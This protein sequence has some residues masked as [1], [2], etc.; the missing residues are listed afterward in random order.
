MEREKIEQVVG[1]TTDGE[2]Y[3]L[4]YVFDETT[5]NKPFRGAVGSVMRPISIREADEAMEVENA[6]DR[7]EDV[8]REC[9]ANGDETRSLDDFVESILMSEGIE[10]MF[11]LSYYSIGE[12]VAKLYNEELPEDHDEKDEAE[13]SE[14]VGGGR[15]FSHSLEFDKVH[16]QDLLDLALS[17]ESAKTLKGLDKQ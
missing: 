1:R 7:Y 10:A 9:V 17:H 11:D 13:F 12:E 16:R 14:C 5:D 2:Y 8:W 6:T 4:D 3:V 15:C